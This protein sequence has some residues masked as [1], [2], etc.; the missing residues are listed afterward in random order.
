MY[1][2]HENGVFVAD[3]H[4][5]TDIKE[6]ILKTIEKSEEISYEKW[7]KRPIGQ[8]IIQNALYILSPPF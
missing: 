5:V 1:I 6:N 4:I 7:K 3:S 2:H 8:K